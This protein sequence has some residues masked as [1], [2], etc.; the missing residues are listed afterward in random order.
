MFP[1]NIEPKRFALIPQRHRHSQL[2]MLQIRQRFIDLIVAVTLRDKTL[3]FD[4][5]ELRHL[6]YF[7]DVVRLTARYSGYRD[8][9]GD[10]IAAADRKRPIAQ[11]ANDC[12]RT[13]GPRCLN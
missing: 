2:S 10:E 12:C 3:Q 11:A 6:K 4:P 13:A 8:F 5:A 9:T 7:F 1:L